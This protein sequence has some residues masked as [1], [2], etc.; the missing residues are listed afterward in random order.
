MG[1]NLRV[2]NLCS[3]PI[4][5]NKTNRTKIVL[6]IYLALIKMNECAKKI[7]GEYIW[8]NTGILRNG[9]CFSGSSRSFMNPELQDEDFKKVKPIVGDIDVQV[10]KNKCEMLS[11]LLYPETCFN[12]LKYLGR[13]PNAIGQI[14]AL[15][16]FYKRS[17]YIQIDFEFVDF[18]NGK[19]SKWAQFSRSSD[20]LDMKHGIKGVFHKY[21]LGSVDFA[22]QHPAVIMK[23]KSKKITSEYV[24]DFAFSVAHG[25]RKKYRAINIDGEYVLEEIQRSEANYVKDIPSIFQMLFGKNPTK[26]DLV[27]INSFVGLAKMAGKYFDDWE[28]NKIWKEFLNRTIGSGAQKL[29]RDDPDTDKKEKKTA[30][31]YLA[32]ELGMD[33]DEAIKMFAS[34]YETYQGRI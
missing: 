10:D 22:S 28:K 15:F 9:T 31:A 2:G 30:I 8:E 6:E 33:V 14:S 7:F 26:E 3:E 16:S 1:G 11:A 21:L 17:E 19:P 20:W 27:D 32:N 25:L 29:Y 24:H 12:G 4:N 23:G 34:Y 18:E 13:S 5:L